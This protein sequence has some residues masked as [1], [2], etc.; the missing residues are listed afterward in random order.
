MFSAFYAIFAFVSLFGGGNPVSTSALVE[1][2]APSAHVAV[3]ASPVT[4]VQTT[5]HTASSTASGQDSTQSSSTQVPVPAKAVI[6]AKAASQPESKPASVAVP[7]QKAAAPQSCN[8]NYSGC[9]K[10]NA[11]DYDCIGGKGDGPNYT[12]KVQVIGEDVFNL[13]RDHDGWGCN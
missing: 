8:P 11:G 2:S 4:K 5:K 6:P 13:D 7:I 10:T 1:G 3:P 9:L 12:G